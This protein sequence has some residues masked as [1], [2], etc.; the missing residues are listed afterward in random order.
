[1]AVSIMKRKAV[2]EATGMC[3]TSIYNKEKLGTFPARRKL[4]IRAVGWVR[5]EVED[6]I[7]KLACA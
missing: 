5:S 3:Y 1:M 7:E 6:W 2:V 4:G